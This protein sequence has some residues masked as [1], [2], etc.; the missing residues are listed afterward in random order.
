MKDISGFELT[1]LD[2]PRKYDAGV[3]SIGYRIDFSQKLIVPPHQDNFDIYGICDSS[4]TNQ[5]STAYM[6]YIIQIL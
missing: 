2:I 3:M 6:L 1:Y 5:V 4:C